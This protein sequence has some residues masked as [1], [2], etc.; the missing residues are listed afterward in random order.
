MFVCLFLKYIIKLQY[1]ASSHYRVQWFFSYAFQNDHH[2]KSSYDISPQRYYLVI[3]YIPHTVHLIP[4]T[5]LF[6]KWK[7]VSLYLPHLFLS[8]PTPSL[9]TI[10]LFSVSVTLFLFCNV[11]SFVLFLDSTFKWN[12]T[13]FVFLCLAYF[14]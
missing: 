6:C 1:Y 10:C 7:F 5:H 14:T 11:Y 12:D 2:N 3:D 8:S 9:V 13:V 4:M